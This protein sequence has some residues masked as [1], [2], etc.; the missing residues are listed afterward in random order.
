MFA[1]FKRFDWRRL[2]GAKTKT[3]VKNV[4]CC[5]S[6]IIIIMWHNLC[7]KNEVNLLLFFSAK[8][9]IFVDFWSVPYIRSEILKHVK[10]LKSGFKWIQDQFFK[11]KKLFFTIFLLCRKT[12]FNWTLGIRFLKRTNTMFIENIFWRPL[13][14]FV[15]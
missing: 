10:N 13:K 14:L 7:H 11:H 12:H 9:K 1:K 8:F 3:I 2:A 5:I 4:T 6:E 15:T